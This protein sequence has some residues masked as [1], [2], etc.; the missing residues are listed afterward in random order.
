MNFRRIAR[1]RMIINLCLITNLFLVFLLCGCVKKTPKT[2]GEVV[3][4]ALIA[5]NNGN[6]SEAESYFSPGIA[7][8]ARQYFLEKYTDGRTLTNVDQNIQIIDE[9][10]QGDNASVRLDVQFTVKRGSLIGKGTTVYLHRKN[11]E[12]KITGN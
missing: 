10:V 11:S 4:A 9:K 2:P 7:A 1:M 12:W 5:F 6:D 3:K 8:E